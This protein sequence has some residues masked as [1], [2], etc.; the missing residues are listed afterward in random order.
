[1]SAGDF[2]RH[3][4][5]THPYVPTTSSPTR[6]S[7]MS[8]MPPSLLSKTVLRIDEGESLSERLK[9]PR[10]RRATHVAVFSKGRCIGVTSCREADWS[11][12]EPA[13]GDLVDAQ[14]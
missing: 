9:E 13:V 4:L 10:S 3:V 12:S 14:R 6:V 7:P 1:M 8:N 5:V 2:G 11:S